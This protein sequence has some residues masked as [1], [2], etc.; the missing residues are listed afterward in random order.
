MKA[1]AK[2]REQQNTV[3]EIAQDAA[4]GVRIA[5][6]LGLMALDALVGK[7]GYELRR[8]DSVLV[9]RRPFRRAVPKPKAKAKAKAKA[10]VKDKPA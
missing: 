6:T 4:N 9:A 2:K 5:A 3:E 10:K 8:K 7:L 1:Y